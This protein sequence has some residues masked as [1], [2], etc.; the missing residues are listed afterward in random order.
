MEAYVYNGKIV[1]EYSG[2]QQEMFGDFEINSTYP[3]IKYVSNPGFRVNYNRR[4]ASTSS[5]G[6]TEEKE[7]TA[8]QKFCDF[9]ADSTV[10]GVRYVTNPKFSIFRR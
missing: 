8:P 6:I 3:G 9:G 1:K 5:S 7:K 2:K 4:V 10:H